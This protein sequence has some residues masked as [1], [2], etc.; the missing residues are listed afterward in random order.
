MGA[1]SPD[2][3][4]L[5]RRGCASVRPITRTGFL[6]LQ[7]VVASGRQPPGAFLP[8]LL[9]AGFGFGTAPSF[10]AP[11]GASR[12]KARPGSIPCTGAGSHSSTVGIRFN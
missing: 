12:D 5:A 7:G 10:G 11:G 2:R 3:W 9:P 4:Y 1:G 6:S 8:Q